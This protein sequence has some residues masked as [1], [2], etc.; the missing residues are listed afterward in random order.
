LGSNLNEIHKLFLIYIR[1][2]KFKNKMIKRGA[3]RDHVRLI[4]LD[5][6]LGYVKFIRILKLLDLNE[7]VKGNDFYISV[8]FIKLQNYYT[9]FLNKNK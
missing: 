4:R 9:I 8:N 7:T 5:P 1:E 6:L 2:I 3:L